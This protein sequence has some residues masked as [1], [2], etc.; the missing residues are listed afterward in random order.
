MKIG[1]VDH[2]FDD[3]ESIKNGKYPK[4]YEHEEASGGV[5]Y[6][7]GISGAGEGCKG[8]GVASAHAVPLKVAGFQNYQWTELKGANAGWKLSDTDT[9]N[10]GEAAVLEGP[11]TGDNY[12]FYEMYILLAEVVDSYECVSESVEGIKRI[13]KV[14]EVKISHV[15]PSFT[16]L[17]RC[18]F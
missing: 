12:C 8:N 16:L 18:N 15:A 10:E 9:A 7:S 1:V 6:Q 17:T 5:D 11:R 3:L 4:G 2:A 14:R 13:L